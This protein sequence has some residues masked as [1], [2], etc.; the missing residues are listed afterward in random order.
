MKRQ[1][2]SDDVKWSEPGG[3]GFPGA[4][5]G[6]LPHFCESVQRFRGCNGNFEVDLRWVS[7]VSQRLGLIKINLT[8]T[9]VG[10]GG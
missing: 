8:Q 6:N 1:H 9:L 5:T 10:A 3:G 4:V 2:T 7:D